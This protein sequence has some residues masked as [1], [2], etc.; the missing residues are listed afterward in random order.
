MCVG[1]T[2]ARQHCNHLRKRLHEIGLKI[3]RLTCNNVLESLV[4][5]SLTIVSEKHSAKA[6]PAEVWQLA[7]PASDTLA[8]FPLNL[9]LFSEAPVRL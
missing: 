4:T 5:S 3:T 2:E 7:S 6:R 9:Y 1:M 8:L